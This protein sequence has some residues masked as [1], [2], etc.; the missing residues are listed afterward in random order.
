MGQSG[1]RDMYGASRGG[2]ET[3]MY[4]GEKKGESMHSE[5][6]GTNATHAFGKGG[7]GGRT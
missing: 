3:D 5:E 4:R 2:K 1:E 7:G 6:E